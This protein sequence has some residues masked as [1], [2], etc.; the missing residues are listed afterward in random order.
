MFGIFKK[1]KTVERMVNQENNGPAPAGL[2]YS[3]INSK[4]V[5]Y[6]LNM[7]YVSLRGGKLVPIYYFSK[8]IRK[9]ASPLPDGYIV[10]ENPRNGFLT[11]RRPE[12][13]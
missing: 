10:N 3:H 9:E 12:Q 8:E 4:G 5:K 13:I 6:Y 1:K 11:V 2:Q 7:K